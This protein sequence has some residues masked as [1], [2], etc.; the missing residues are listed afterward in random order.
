MAKKTTKQDNPFKHRDCVHARDF[1]DLNYKGEPILCRCDYA[2]FAILLN[3]KACL[4]HFKK[5]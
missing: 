1:F 2:E 4:K 5:K 3:D